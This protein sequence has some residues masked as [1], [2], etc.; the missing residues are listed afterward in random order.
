MKKLLWFHDTGYIQMEER[1]VQTTGT[2]SVLN[3][4]RRFLR[5][6]RKYC[7]DKK[8]NRRGKLTLPPFPAQDNLMIPRFFRVNSK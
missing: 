7:D 5:N 4:D 6:K 3:R 1:P 2:A 8:G